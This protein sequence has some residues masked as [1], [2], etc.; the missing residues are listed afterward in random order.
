M[1]IACAP[2]AQADTVPKDC[3]RRSC[4]IATT[5]EAALAIRSGIES[6]EMRSAPSSRMTM[7]CAS[8]V[9]MPPI[10]VPITQAG[11]VRVDGRAVVPAGV[12][13]RLARPRPARAA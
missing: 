6:G 3:P 4:F 12:L 13:E 8:S 11:A 9:P 2:A 7:C 10:P 1:P 5:P